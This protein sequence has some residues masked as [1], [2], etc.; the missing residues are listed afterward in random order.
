[1]AKS[2]RIKAEAV[3]CVQ[4]SQDLRAQAHLVVPAKESVGVRAQ[5]LALMDELPNSALEEVRN[6]AE[7]LKTK[8]SRELRAH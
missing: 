4:F 8:E 1:M 2:C 7:F 3:I 5:L 6:F